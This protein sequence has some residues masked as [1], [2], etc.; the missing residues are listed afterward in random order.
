M[1]PRALRFT[2][3]SSPKMSIPSGRPSF[4]SSTASLAGGTGASFMLDLLE[5]ATMLTIRCQDIAFGAPPGFLID[6]SPDAPLD[7]A[8]HRQLYVARLTILHPEPLR[9]RREFLRILRAKD[10]TFHGT[11]SSFTL[12][13]PFALLREGD[14][15]E[16]PATDTRPLFYQYTT[17]SGHA[18]RPLTSLVSALGAMIAPRRPRRILL[19]AAPCAS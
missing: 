5:A 16:M 12:L 19:K 15:L 17:G 11:Y 3:R 1:G 10:Y 8:R 14:L 18:I 9:T 2:R 6:F 13:L 4:S 7:P